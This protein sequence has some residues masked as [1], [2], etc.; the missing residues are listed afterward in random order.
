MLLRVRA[1]TLRGRGL[2]VVQQILLQAREEV[3][4]ERDVVRDKLVGDRAWARAELA[5]RRARL[6]EARTESLGREVRGLLLLIG[7]LV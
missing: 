4:A 6:L 1:A 7:L 2:D 5:A 3:D